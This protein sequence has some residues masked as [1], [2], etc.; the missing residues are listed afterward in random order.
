MTGDGLP[1]VS[2]G[3]GN[4]HGQLAGAATEQPIRVNVRTSAAV[5]TTRPTAAASFSDTV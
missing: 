2:R 1:T 5:G 3:S 4:S